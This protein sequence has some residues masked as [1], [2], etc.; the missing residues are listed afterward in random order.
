[1]DLHIAVCLST[2]LTLREQRMSV[3]IKIVS[4]P[5]T[6]HEHQKSSLLAGRGLSL[7][8]L[9]SGVVGVGGSGGLSPGSKAARRH[10]FPSLGL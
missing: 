3:E 2:D 10:V 4:W 9:L 7:A 6:Y 5:S 1:M 8:A